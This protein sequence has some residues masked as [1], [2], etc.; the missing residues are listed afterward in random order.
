[1]PVRNFKRDMWASLNKTTT[2]CTLAF[3]KA[4]V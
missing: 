2:P 3:Y 4:T 1:L